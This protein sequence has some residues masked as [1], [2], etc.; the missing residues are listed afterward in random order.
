MIKKIIR[1][2]NTSNENINITIKIHPSQ[3]SLEEYRDLVHKIDP[4]IKI[5][6]R[7]PILQ[8]LKKAD[9]IISSS[10]STAMFCGLLLKKPLIIHNCFS[11]RS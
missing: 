1:E 9:V 10:S 11:S 5:Y 3:E 8:L 7:E 4:S 2:I 6:Q